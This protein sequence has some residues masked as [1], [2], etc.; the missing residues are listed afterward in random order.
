MIKTR[1]APSPTGFLHVGGLRTALYAY[2]FAKK[3]GGVFVLRIEDTDRERFI[4]GGIENIVRS[5]AWVGLRPDEGV[6]LD[7]MG[8]ITQKGDCGPYIQSE[9]LDIYKKYVDE[10]IKNG[11]AYYCFCSKERLDELRKMQELNKMPTGYDQHCCNCPKDEIEKRIK[12]GEPHVARMK[13]P[14]EGTT[15]FN[16]LI[17]GEVEFKNELIDDQVILKADGYPTYH[18][19]VVVDDHLMEITH[20]IRGEEWLSSTPKHIQLYKM[21]GWKA[22]E[23]AHL[24]LLL[25]PDKSKLSKRQGD[26]AVEDYKAK[27][28]LPEAMVNFVAF[29]GWNPGT[30]KE[31]FN[32]DGLAKEFDLS[33]VNKSGAVFN[34]PK[35][36]WYNEQYIRAMDLPELVE[37]CIPFLIEAR[38]IKD[39]RK[40][41][42]EYKKWLKGVIALERGRVV[43][44]S[45]ISD[46]LKFVFTYKL[47][48]DAEILVWKKS[49]KKETKENLNLLIELLSKKSI[50]LWTK[51]NLELIVGEWVKDKGL[52]NG[53][54]LWPMRVALSGQEN[55]P[56]PFEIAE[57]LGRE[58]TIERFTSAF[59]S[60]K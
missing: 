47:N 24:P 10:L 12:S 14:K 27:G 45:Q 48:Y 16:D 44:L 51:K 13:M 57:V 37:R 8:K 58:K 46:A 56:G 26:V 20:V 33:R 11:H 52:N 4:D 29:L 28:Y 32:L 2:L 17:K 53:S 55:S 34:L 49:T 43:N 54:V 31:L 22:P 5:L 40:I 1:F 59:K 60:I 38:L 9:R 21:F 35:L 36:D 15:K 41:T 7:K 50:Q 23:F 30:D 19:A 3:Q 6:D 25:N 42:D 39:Y 18:L